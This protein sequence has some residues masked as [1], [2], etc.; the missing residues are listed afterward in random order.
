MY[1]LLKRWYISDCESDGDSGWEVVGTYRTIRKARQAMHKDV[2]EVEFA[3]CY[4]H[5]DY[6]G[7]DD[8]QKSTRISRNEHIYDMADS[9]GSLV[10]WEIVR[11][12]KGFGKQLWEVG[13]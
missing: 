4:Q 10:H 6:G 3:N 2:R 12:H 13:L 9:C 5:P 1:R 11:G 8:T 7:L